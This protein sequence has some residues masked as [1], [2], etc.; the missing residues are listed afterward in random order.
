MSDTEVR[1]AGWV[2]RWGEHPAGAAVLFLLAVLEAC[3]FPAPTEVLFVALGLGRP[4]RS[5]WLAAIATLGS[6]TGAL[7]GYTFGAG[8]YRQLGAPLLE[9][10]GL[11]AQFDT[12]A[13][14]YRGNAF[15]VLGTS[16]YT[17]IPF[18]LYTIVAGA[19]SLPLTTFLAGSLIGRG[20][21]FVLLS[22]L[23]Y[24]VGPRLRA[25]SRRTLGWVASLILAA[26]ALWWLLTVAAP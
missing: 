15:L 26:A 19:I 18:V 7:I 3:V 25:A 8:F 16:G 22:V 14:L 5:W 1:R 9:R 17:P 21:K 10:V 24:Y 2:S 20:L 6:V 4:R 11:A 23:T 13:T 12:V